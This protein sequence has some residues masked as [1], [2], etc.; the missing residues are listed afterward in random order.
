M[1]ELPFRQFTQLCKEY[2]RMEATYPPLEFAGSCKRRDQGY[3][4]KTS[5]ETR[6]CPHHLTHCSNHQRELFYPDRCTKTN[7][8]C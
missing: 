8:D 7:D 4:H 3:C 5:V 1:S 2:Q 6:W